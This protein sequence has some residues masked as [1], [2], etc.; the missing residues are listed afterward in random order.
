MNS[1][2]P[3]PSQPSQFSFGLHRA[4]SDEQDIPS[5]IHD[6]SIDYSEDDEDNEDNVDII[7]RG[8]N[9]SE[10]DRLV[11]E[12]LGKYTTLFEGSGKEGWRKTELKE[13]PDGT[14]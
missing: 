10:A 7:G 6:H 5:T 12:L 2:I 11:E 3:L 1:K 13:I 8:R 4:A 9:E 14:L